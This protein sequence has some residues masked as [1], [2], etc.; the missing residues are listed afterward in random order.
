MG[1]ELDFASPDHLAT[2]GLDQLGDL[3]R[4]EDHSTALL[5]HAGVD[6]LLDL[7]GRRGAIPHPVVDTEAHLARRLADD[8]EVIA[9]VASVGVDLLLV[10]WGWCPCRPPL[11]HE[12]SET[13]KYESIVSHHGQL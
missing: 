3:V 8:D 9:I 12:W 11:Y 10:W 13:S 6:G 7:A 1:V 4:G 5:D 2:E